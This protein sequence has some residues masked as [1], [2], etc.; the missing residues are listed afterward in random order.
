MTH[1]HTHTHA[2][3]Y[4]RKWS[5]NDLVSGW[6]N[7]GWL[8]GMAPF[9]NSYTV[10]LLLIPRQTYLNPTRN[11]RSG[12][13]SCA[14]NKRLQRHQ[15]QIHGGHQRFWIKTNR[16]WPDIRRN[17]SVSSRQPF[18]TNQSWLDWWESWGQELWAHHK[19]QRKS[20]GNWAEKEKQ[21]TNHRFSQHT[22]LPGDK[23]HVCWSRSR[24]RAFDK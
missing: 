15:T 17:P 4:T 10:I 1:A 16:G 21:Q 2:H 19:P 11:V 18:Q 22:F 23:R 9:P 12:R 13:W 8:Y 5:G 24:E 14:T 7:L 20:W 3:T 6:P